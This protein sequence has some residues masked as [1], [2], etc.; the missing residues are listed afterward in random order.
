MSWIS[1]CPGFLH[2]PDFSMSD[3]DAF[4]MSRVHLEISPKGWN[5]YGSLEKQMSRALGAFDP[6][7]PDLRSSSLCSAVLP[8]KGT[9]RPQEVLSHSHGVL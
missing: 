9:A 7:A 4:H 2:V 6:Q 8:S 1:A 5:C 3:F